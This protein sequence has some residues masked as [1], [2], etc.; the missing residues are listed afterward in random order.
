MLTIALL[1]LVFNFVMSSMR[2]PE[3]TRTPE[4]VLA[5]MREHNERI[6]DVSIATQ[7]RYYEGK[8][9]SLKPPP[10]DLQA[11]LIEANVLVAQTQFKAGT[12]RKEMQR[13]QAAYHTLEGL[14]NK[15][16]TDPAWTQ[17]PVQVFDDPRFGPKEWTGKALFA[18]VVSDL[19]DVSEKEMVWGAIPG[20]LLIDG[21]V[22]MTGAIPGFSYAF[23]ALLL[24]FIVRAI[25]FPVSQKQMMWS[26][27]MSQLQPLIA[28]IRDK[29]K[30]NMQEQQAKIMELYKEYG[31]NPMAGCLPMLLQLPLFL[32]VYQCMLLYRFEF[33]KGT[34]LWINPSTSAATG[35]FIAP[36]LGQMDYIL[37]ALYGVSM[38]ATS[39]LMPVSDPSNAKQQRIMG[40]GVSALVAVSMFFYP[41]PSAFV[42]YWT[43]ANVFATAQSLR[44]YR[45]PLPPLMKV[46]TKAGG[47]YPAEAPG[48]N[49]AGI[50]LN[51]HVKTG[52][53]VKHRPKK[54]K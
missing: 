50:K 52:K 20:Y 24:A 17:T 4:Q 42:L 6:E 7:F 14:D 31:I 29:Y 41:L 32:I 10:A 18:K 11:K 26:R 5:K 44:A 16:A 36:N 49:G 46:N 53:P 37:L 35:G 2:A 47:V 19:S 33:T 8:L 30:P 27:Q 23:A 45:L 28:E 25:V 21:L 1:F 40:V 9:K 22:K 39:L 3:D 13:L 15:L 43:F 38:I 12:Q 34:F 48:G 51:G 54:R